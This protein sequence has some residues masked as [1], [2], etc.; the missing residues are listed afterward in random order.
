MMPPRHRTGEAHEE[1]TQPGCAAPEPG[2]TT[3]THTDDTR[4][5]VNDTLGP[6]RCRPPHRFLQGDKPDSPN[7]APTPAQAV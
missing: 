4:D 1:P 7:P 3:Q 2:T 5:P 6:R